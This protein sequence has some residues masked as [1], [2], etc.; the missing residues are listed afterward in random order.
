MVLLYLTTAQGHS[1]AA[2]AGVWLL[3]LT[4]NTL[5]RHMDCRELRWNVYALVALNLLGVNTSEIYYGWCLAA[6]LALGCGWVWVEMTAK[7]NPSRYRVSLLAFGVLL[8]TIPLMHM[9]MRI[10]A[11]GLGIVFQP[12]QGRYSA[13]L[14]LNFWRNLGIAFLGWFSAVPV[15]W[16]RLPNAP[17]LQRVVPFIGIL[18]AAGLCVLPWAL[19]KRSIRT[20]GC[21]D[22]G[23]LVLLVAV[24]SFLGVSA[25]LPTGNMSESYLLGV[26]IGSAVLLAV[27]VA[28]LIDIARRTWV[29]MAVIVAVALVLVIGEVGVVSRAVNFAVGWS[30][31]GELYAQVRTFQK[32]APPRR[33]PYL[34]LVPRELRAGFT[35]GQYV[36]PP[37]IS[38]NL[39]L[40]SLV[41]NRLSPQ[42]RVKPTPSSEASVGD[43]TAAEDL[44][45]HADLILDGRGLVARPS[46]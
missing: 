17:L 31:A 4:W 16:A 8:V 43:G 20:S 2:G 3:I 36:H 32:R 18:L 46:W 37:A 38:L 1:W 11:G 44:D 26:N 5:E 28:L 23:W 12:D 13:S 14:G 15:H 45:A 29:R 35:H 21:A 42:A 25:T 7:P 30:N 27:G 40:A 24:A 34:V 6:G 9:A 33:E 39:G 41:A 19:R 10:L 22:N